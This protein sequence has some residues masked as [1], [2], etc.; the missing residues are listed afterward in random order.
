MTLKKQLKEKNC[1]GCGVS[2]HKI[3]DKKHE[4]NGICVDEV[5]E[6]D[7]DE[8]YAHRI[9]KIIWCQE[10]HSKKED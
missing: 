5:V 10:R 3:D 6:I 1:I 2:F 9:Q 8:R 7:K 4:Y